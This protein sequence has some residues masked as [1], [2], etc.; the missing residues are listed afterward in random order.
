M[1]CYYGNILENQHA[2]ASHFL[3]FFLEKK[4]GC[5]SSF[6]TSQSVLAT[7]YGTRLM[8]EWRA[9]ECKKIK[10]RNWAGGEG[11]GEQVLFYKG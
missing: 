9:S 5:L 8:A 10:W 4:S 3:R 11:G 6:K 2:G 1:F 7:V